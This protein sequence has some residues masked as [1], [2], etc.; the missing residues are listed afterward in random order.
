MTCGSGGSTPSASAG[1]PSVT[2]LFHRSCSG[3]SAGCATKNCGHEDDQHLGDVARQQEQDGLLDVVEDDAA[4]MHRLDDGREVVVGQD[5]VRGLAGHVR[6]DSA[7]RHADVGALERRRVVDAV[8]GHG[9]DVAAALER[10][11]DP[12][13]VLR[14]HAR[15]DP[16]VLDLRGQLL[17]GHRREL[18][19]GDD[20]LPFEQP[21]AVRRSPRAVSAWS[22]V[23]IA[24]WMPARVG[25][26][27]RRRGP[28]GEAGRRGPRCRGTRS[29]RSSVAGSRG[30]PGSAARP[31][32]A[33][34]SRT[35]G[36]GSPPPP[37]CRCRRGDRVAAP[38][39]AATSR[40]E[41]GRRSHSSSTTSVPPFMNASS[42]AS[43][44]MD[45]RHALALGVERDLRHAARPD[46]MLGQMRRPR[47]AARSRSGRRRGVPSASKWASFA[48]AATARSRSR[49]AASGAAA[50]GSSA[51]SG[52]AV[53]GVAAHLQP[54]DA[55]LVAGERPGLVGA[56]E[57]RRAER[58]DRVEPPHDRVARR[59]RLHADGER[60]RDD[61]G[62]A[63]GDRRDGERDR[64]EE[65]GREHVLEVPVPDVV[66]ERAAQAELSLDDA[67]DEDDRGDR[68][69][70]DGEPRA[71]PDAAPAGAASAPPPCSRAARRRGPSRCAVPWR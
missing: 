5:H 42:P 22:P 71:R 36:S 20:A 18:G 27:D 54:R 29:P 51:Q 43:D 32:P 10:L 55:H 70:R 21:D 19:A 14:V 44:R 28:R 52:V 16:D 56:D 31:R 15:V 35:R 23:T 40:R 7:H 63:L 45:R 6:A 62:Q 41:A 17:V 25:A 57:R 69:Y 34:A 53:R 1:A 8:A 64:D 38:R 4:L 49:S 24:T 39:S 30:A 66:Q 47:R 37:S 65:L 3:S 12:Q 60:Q 2:R 61:G 48:P 59:H 68:Q 13:L 11:D 26:G 50:S 67:G 58:L 9:D 33:R 46:P